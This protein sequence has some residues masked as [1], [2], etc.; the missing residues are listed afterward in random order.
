M[1][2]GDNTFGPCSGHHEEIVDLRDQ[3]LTLETIAKQF[4]VT[5]ER[6][7]QIV[8][9]EE[10]GLALFQR[11][12]RAE[13]IALVEKV[14]GCKVPATLHRRCCLC[15]KLSGES[16]SKVGQAKFCKACMGKMKAIASI[17]HRVEKIDQAP[18]YLSQ[19]AWTIK[20]FGITHEQFRVFFAVIPDSEINAIEEEEQ[21]PCSPE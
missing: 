14:V 7:R 3:N 4:G 2:Q 16:R 8:N 12:R 6:I 21:T 5:R 15:G 18:Y 20:K 13:N 11:T 17:A 19:A 10:G 1:T 9:A